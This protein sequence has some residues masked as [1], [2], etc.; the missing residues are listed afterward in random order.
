MQP[1]RSLRQPAGQPSLISTAQS[2]SIRRTPPTLTSVTA[3]RT[4][5]FCGDQRPLTLTATL[6]QSGGASISYNFR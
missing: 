2:V 5:L 4:A 3:S 1:E 6:S